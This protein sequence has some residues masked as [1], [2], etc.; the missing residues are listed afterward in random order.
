MAFCGNCG[1]QLPDGMRFCPNC[2]TAVTSIENSSSL[3]A[4]EN[5]AIENTVNEWQPVP[6][7]IPRMET[8][9]MYIDPKSMPSKPVT[10]LDKYGK[11]LGIPLFILSI[12]DFMTDPPLLTILLSIAIISG[13]VFCLANKYKLKFFTITSIILASICL[14]AGAFQANKYGILKTPSDSEYEEALFGKTEQPSITIEKSNEV[15]DSVKPDKKVTYGNV[16]FNIPGKYLEKTQSLANEDIY[17]TKDELAMFDM[18]LYDGSIE[19]GIF[20]SS[21]AQTLLESEF[22]TWIDEKIGNT[23]FESS[24]Y[25]TVAG[26]DCIELN[27]IGTADGVNVKCTLAIINDEASNKMIPV[28]NVYYDHMASDYGNDLNNMLNNASRKSGSTVSEKS[29]ENVS[30]DDNN[31]SAE[32]VDPKLKAALDEYEDFMNEYVDFMNKYSSDPGN[33]LSMISEY[34]DMLAKYSDFATKI[35]EMD[36]SNMSKAD[37]AYYLDTL[38]RVEKKLLDVVQ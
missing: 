10:W 37:Y 18:G 14:I 5:R 9:A 35:N 11:F 13:A 7:Q 29:D 31:M 19:G 17:E 27:Y 33:A 3:E 26:F 24:Q 28:L 16:V 25:R 6:H 4:D 23:R 12:I 22:K 38:N 21:E 1:N 20:K 15:K 30:S 8:R 36:T 2:G 32:G 34:T